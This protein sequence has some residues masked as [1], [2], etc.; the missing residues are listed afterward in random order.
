M[1]DNCKIIWVN[2]SFGGS[3]HDMTIAKRDLIPYLQ[4]CEC[5][6]ADKGYYGDS[7]LVCP[8]KQPVVNDIQ[9]TFNTH[10]HKMRQSIERM[11]MRLKKFNCITDVWRHDIKLHEVVFIIICNITNISLLFEPLDSK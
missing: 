9:K 6:L 10:H 7:K 11:N 5:L 3:V 2:G 4:N 8:F 1:G